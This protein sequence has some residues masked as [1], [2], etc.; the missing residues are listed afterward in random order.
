MLS[1]IWPRS[2]PGW[3]GDRIEGLHQD[4]AVQWMKDV[5]AALILGGTQ[6]HLMYKSANSLVSQRF[7]EGRRLG[8]NI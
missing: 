7:S 5:V 1:T 6:H 2:C 8:L 4:A 3:A